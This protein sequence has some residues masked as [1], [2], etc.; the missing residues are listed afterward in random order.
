MVFSEGI[1][2]E[3][4]K[5]EAVKQWPKPQLVRDIQVFLGFANFYHRFIQGFSQ[6][7]AILTSM[8][9]TSGSTES[10]TRP[11]KCRVGVGGDSRTGHNNSK[12]D[13]I[14]IGEDKIGDEVDDEVGKKGRTPTKSKNLFKSKKTELGFF[15]FGAKRAFTKLRQAFIKAPILHH[16]HQ[17]RHIRVETDVLGYAI[18]GVLSQL[19]SDDLGRW[20]PVVFFLQKMIPAEIRY[21][22]HNNELLAIVEVFKTW[23]HYLEEFQNEVLVL[24][25]HNN[26]R[27]FMD[28]KSW[29]SRQVRR[30]QKLSCYHF[31]IDYCL[32]KANTAADA[33]SRFSQKSHDEEK[34]LQA[35]NTQIF[36]YL[37]TSLTN[38]SL[39]G[40]SLNSAINLSPLHRVLICETHM[41]LQLHQFW[42]TFQSQWKFLQS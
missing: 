7:A 9:K 24:I 13:K 1:H 29:S 10:L 11:E 39:S 23:R 36:Y 6:I 21:E 30:A 4:K 3:D 8:L 26:L 33:L 12:L 2:M 19:T 34:K 25:D 41:L 31:R 42:D 35:K 27:R 14:G 38:A 37:Q 16:F 5:I 40:L 28:T 32:G 17:E 15:T 22:T 18:G 20:H